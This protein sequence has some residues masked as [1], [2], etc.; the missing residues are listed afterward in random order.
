MLEKL[1]KQ[2]KGGK[3]EN[4]NVIELPDYWPYL[5]DSDTITVTLTPKNTY[6]QLYVADI[7]DNTIIINSSSYKSITY[8][9]RCKIIRIC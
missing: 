8:G 2:Y 5:V 3:L 1:I 4:K 9:I 6:Q 7:V